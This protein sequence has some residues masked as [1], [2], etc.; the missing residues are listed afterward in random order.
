MDA[1]SRQKTTIWERLEQN[2]ES[3]TIQLSW[4]MSVH[5]IYGR[6]RA[7]FDLLEDD[8][9]RPEIILHV[10]TCGMNEAYRLFAFRP[11]E[12]KDCLMIVPEQVTCTANVRHFHGGPQDRIA[13]IG[14]GLTLAVGQ[15]A[16]PSA[17][18]AVQPTVPI[19]DMAVSAV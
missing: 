15:L 14:S 19:P 10:Q 17:E 11:S 3:R 2:V 6:I 8:D 9:C 1:L 4:A 13:I 7:Q 16:L 12:S 5:G 18:P